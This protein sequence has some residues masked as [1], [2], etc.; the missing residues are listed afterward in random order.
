M[1]TAWQLYNS[2][3][4]VNLGWSGLGSTHYELMV[5]ACTSG[6]FASVC[7]LISP[8]WLFKPIS[9]DK[10]KIIHY[11]GGLKCHIAI[12]KNILHFFSHFLNSVHYMKTST[13]YLLEFL[14][15]WFLFIYIALFVFICFI[16]PTCIPTPW[17][18][19][20]HWTPLVTV[21]DHCSRL[22]Y[23]NIC[24]NKRITK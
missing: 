14:F 16:Y 24:T 19:Q 3:K 10:L 4:L 21:K 8:M 7:P 9:S 6:C 2:L 17:K 11:F 15:V 1:P 5:D 23:P 13:W 18:H 22:P 20:R 12:E